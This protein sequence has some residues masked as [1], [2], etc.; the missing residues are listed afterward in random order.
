MASFGERW[1]VSNLMPQ[2]SAA[3]FDFSRSGEDGF[4][5]KKIPGQPV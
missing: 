5:T 2:Q 1:A 3:A 4:T